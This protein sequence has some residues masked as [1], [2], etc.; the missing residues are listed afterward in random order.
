MNHDHTAEAR[1]AKAHP[2][3]VMLAALFVLILGT[4]VRPKIAFAQT[5]AI[6]VYVEGPDA[7]AVRSSRKRTVPG[8]CR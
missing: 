3:G 5:S 6:V 8:S 2:V 1:V 7:P 4:L